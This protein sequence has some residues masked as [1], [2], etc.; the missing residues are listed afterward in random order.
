MTSNVEGIVRSEVRRWLAGVPVTAE[1]MVEQFEAFLKQAPAQEAEK[2]SGFLVGFT[3]SLMAKE[4][5]HD[6]R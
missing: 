2:L 6:D 4:T 5:K 1:D 3:T